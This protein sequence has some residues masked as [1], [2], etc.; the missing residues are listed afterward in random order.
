[1][2]LQDL[3]QHFVQAVTAGND[4]S[5][6]SLIIG[7]GMTQQQRLDIYR[8]NVRA[9]IHHTM[10]QTFPTIHALVGD[11]F[12][13]GCIKHYLENHTP[14]SSNL[15]EYGGAFSV[16]LQQFKPA[17]SIPYLA[18][19]AE[20]EWLIHSAHHHH[21]SALIESDYPVHHIWQMHQDEQVKTTVLDEN[22]HYRILVHA[23]DDA[24]HLRELTEAE[25]YTI[26]DANAS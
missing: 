16:F 4:E 7:N 6:T 17:E 12:F 20:L 24:V 11:D 21:H 23:A 13:Y 14:T 25:Y 2:K 22:V 19:M 9:A 3:Q 5:I 8:N 1:M 26:L 15:D 10:V 18:D